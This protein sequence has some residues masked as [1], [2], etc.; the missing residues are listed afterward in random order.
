M[1]GSV[2]VYALLNLFLETAAAERVLSTQLALI[3]PE[4]RAQPLIPAVRILRYQRDRRTHA[5]TNVR[6]SG[7]PPYFTKR[8]KSVQ[9]GRVL[10]LEKPKGTLIP[11]TLGHN[12]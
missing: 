5:H 4:C 7:I 9:W 12:N 8:D 3:F 10:L 2:G 11:V 1:R 6:G